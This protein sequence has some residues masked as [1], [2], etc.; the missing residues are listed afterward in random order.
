MRSFI[1]NPQ[2]I[3]RDYLSIYLDTDS[4]RV[5]IN[6][7][8]SG[9]DEDTPVS[10]KAIPIGIEEDEANSGKESKDKDPENSGSVKCHREET[11]LKVPLY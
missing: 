11:G 5:S 2:L 8:R 10:T 3:I 7:E 4:I 6:S 9:I 1:E